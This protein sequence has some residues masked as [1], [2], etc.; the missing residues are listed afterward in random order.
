MKHQ[1]T[2][3]RNKSDEKTK[4]Q[5]M[6]MTPQHWADAIVDHF[7]PMGFVL[8]PCCGEGAFTKAIDR[9]LL[10]RLDI[11]LRLQD[12]LMSYDIRGPEGRDF[13]YHQAPCDWIITNPPWSKVAAFLEKGMEVADNI[14]FLITVNHIWTNK[15]QRLIKEAGFG[16]KEICTMTQPPKPWPSSGFTLAAI[17]FQRAWDGPITNTQLEIH[18]D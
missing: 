9:H 15:R 7:Q 10:S 14:V 4:S 18:N 17:H 2:L 8:D 13:M 12:S 3:N 6:V 1:P 16:I 11:E 5:D